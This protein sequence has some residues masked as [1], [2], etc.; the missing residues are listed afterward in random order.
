MD[1]YLLSFAKCIIDFVLFYWVFSW[2]FERKSDKKNLIIFIIIIVSVVLLAFNSFKIAWLNTLVTI[3]CSILMN[4]LIFDARWQAKL[5]SA[6]IVVLI[7]LMCEF[8]PLLILAAMLNNNISDVLTTPINSA[9]FSLISTGCFFVVLRIG[10]SI[11]L[12]KHTGNNDINVNNNGWAILFPVLSIT[13][14][15]Y[16]LYADTFT[17]AT[18]KVTLVHTI[19][20]MV[21]IVSNFGFF[22]GETGVE[23]KYLLQKQLSELR[24][25]QSKADAILKLKDNHIKEM[26]CL[27]HDYDTQLNGLKRMISEGQ[28]DH[29]KGAF[30]VDQLKEN[31]QESNRFLYVESKPL[32]LIL[33]QANDA[34]ITHGIEFNTDIRYASYEFMTF[35]DIF[36]LFENMLDNAINACINMS[37]ASQAKIKLQM[38]KNEGQILILTSN[39]YSKHER[40]DKRYRTLRATKEHG[41]GLHSIKSVVRKYCGTIH[42]DVGTDY[43]ILIS[44]PIG[45]SRPA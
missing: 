18:P 1:T 5:I 6:I 32:Q 29:N 7:C 16:T 4:H 43:K 10:R 30:Y 8:F 35:P 24:F 13:L 45:T 38:L 36:S 37:D 2:F 12:K 14:V 34:C 25:A 27:V 17:L 19:L 41:N 26:Q 15:Y 28:I 20:Y 31:L 9:A 21:I 42:I 44:L 40:G 3:C 33:N 22:F 11:L 23:K 39:T